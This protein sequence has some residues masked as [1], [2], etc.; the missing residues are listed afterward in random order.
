[1]LP[2]IGHIQFASVPE[3]A[4]PDRGELN[5][6]AVFAAIQALGWDRP[7]GAEYKPGDDTDGTLGWMAAFA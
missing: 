1:L 2:I 3:R 5:Y 4:A 7:L 6:A